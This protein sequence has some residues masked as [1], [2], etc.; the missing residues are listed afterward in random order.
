LA[1]GVASAFADSKAIKILM[2]NIMVSGNEG[3]IYNQNDYLA[4]FKQYL[5]GDLDLILMADLSRLEVEKLNRVLEY[6]EM[7]NSSRIEFL[8]ESNCKCELADIATIDEVNWR[9][10]HSKD[11]LA[12]YFVKM[13]LCR[14]KD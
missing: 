7:E 11:K 13:D 14:R 5:K 10:R 3:K 8:P 12:Q 4:L 1:D 6:Y 9:L 2:V